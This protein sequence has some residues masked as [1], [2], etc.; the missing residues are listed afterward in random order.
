MP[1]ALTRSLGVCTGHA[2]APPF[3]DPARRVGGETA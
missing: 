3:A 2:A 1:P